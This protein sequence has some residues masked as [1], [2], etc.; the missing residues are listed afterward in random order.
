MIPKFRAY[1]E[2]YGMRDVVGLYWFDDHLQVTLD[3]GVGSPIRSSDKVVKL[4]RP[5]PFVD[6]NGELIYEGHILTDAGDDWQDGWIYGAVYYDEYERDW[7]VDW[8][9]ESHINYLACERY[10]TIAGNIYENPELL[11]V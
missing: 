8:R 2:Q 3:N 10:K 5:T 4:L 9:S 6:S 1:S 11:E 7:F